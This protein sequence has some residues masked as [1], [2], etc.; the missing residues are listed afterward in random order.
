[1]RTCLAHFLSLFSSLHYL[2]YIKKTFSSTDR[3]AEY[4]LLQLYT[5]TNCPIVKVTKIMD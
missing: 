3:V 2:I 1:M 5:L 4:F